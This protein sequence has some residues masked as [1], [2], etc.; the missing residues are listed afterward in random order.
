M[1][2]VRTNE[3]D[4]RFFETWDEAVTFALKGGGWKISFSIGS[5]RLRFIR[6]EG[7]W[8]YQDIF[9]MY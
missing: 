5:E 4:I 9:G 2:Q 7:K 1:F 6:E 8:V 3:G